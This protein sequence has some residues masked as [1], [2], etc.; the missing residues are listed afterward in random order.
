MGRRPQTKFGRFPSAT[1]VAHSSLYA[2]CWRGVCVLL[3]VL[4][5]W[6]VGF[7][8]L[9][10]VRSADG[11]PWCTS[12]CWDWSDSFVRLVVNVFFVVCFFF[13]VVLPASARCWLALSLTAGRRLVAYEYVVLLLLPWWTK[14]WG[15]GLQPRPQTPPPPPPPCFASSLV[16]QSTPFPSCFVSLLAGGILAHGP[17][18][19]LMVHNADGSAEIG[20]ALSFGR[21]SFLVGCYNDFEKGYLSFARSKLETRIRS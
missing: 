7:T 21:S 6:S 15:S 12:V 17:S 4:R 1:L 14:K 19:G 16:P 20:L 18:A 2:Q 3:P 5:F 11:R 9:M 8:L 13:A 10:A